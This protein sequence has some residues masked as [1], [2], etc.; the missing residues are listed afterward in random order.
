MLLPQRLL[1]YSRGFAFA[2][3][4]LPAPF[5]G[6]LSR[7]IRCRIYEIMYLVTRTARF[8]SCAE[9]SQFGHIWIRL[10]AGAS[11]PWEVMTLPGSCPVRPC[12]EDPSPVTD[13]TV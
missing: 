1:Q 7:K 12:H 5:P 9:S 10:V 4:R 3:P 13:L 2:H 8:S 11:R 6:R